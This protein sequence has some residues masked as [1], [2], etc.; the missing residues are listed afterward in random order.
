M[1]ICIF[2]DSITYGAFDPEKGGWANRLRLH[3]DNKEDFEGEVYNLGISGDN[4]EEL[5]ER[6]ETEAKF[7][8][9]GFL[10][11]AIGVNDSHYVI[12]EQQNRVPIDE[13]KQNIKELMIRA[14]KIT[15]K[16]LFIGLTPVDEAKMTPTT[17]WNAD[18]M[19]K[20]EYVEKYNDII[21]EICK[22][23]KI[24]FVDIFSE[25]MKE[26]YKTMLFD[27]LHPDSKGHEWIADKIISEIK[28]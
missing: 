1:N 24:D 28:I 16:I 25:M 9:P 4:T 10:I 11:F 2:G 19:F 13:F 17:P 23:E 3:L 18:K 6:F 7:R 21:K 27:G 14:R 22:S 5:L 8:E 12:S 15:D 20:N 26:N